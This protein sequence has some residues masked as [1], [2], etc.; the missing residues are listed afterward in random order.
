MSDPLSWMP[1]YGEDFFD[2]EVVEL[3]DPDAEALY[4]R[5][6]WYQW[7]RGG[8]PTDPATIGK[9]VPGKYARRFRA[10][11]KQIE[12]CFPIAGDHRENPRCASE[13]AKAL[14]LLESKRRGAEAAN[15]AREERRRSSSG[16]QSVTHSAT[17]C[18]AQNDTHDPP[19]S[20]SES[21][22][23]VPT[24]DSR[25]G[26][27]PSVENPAR[28]GARD[29]SAKRKAA[30]PVADPIAVLVEPEFSGLAR[31]AAFAAFWPEWNAYRREIHK[32]YKSQRGIREALR[33][34]AAR[35]PQHWISDARRSMANGYQGVFPSADA[36]A[37]PGG[38]RAQNR[39]E[40]A[41][42]AADAFALERMRQLE[43]D[44]EPREAE[45][46]N[47]RGAA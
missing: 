3:A 27:L 34:A 40:A 38:A 30:D 37:P 36:A 42:A 20:A 23:S 11:W 2:A 39:A 16:T 33:E 1:L 47:P 4:L 44:A 8:I 25:Q 6:L 19:K 31:D 22:Q 14:E 26:S 46:L 18:D 45:F 28:A 32:P 41:N 15:A 24:S 21:T 43:P 29:S 17:L 5:L 35:G 7:R 10:L 9:L 12:R 13:R